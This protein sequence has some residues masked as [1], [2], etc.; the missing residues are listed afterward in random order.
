MGHTGW[1]ALMARPTFACFHNIYAHGCSVTGAR[2]AGKATKE[3][4]VR[5]TVPREAACELLLFCV[6]APL[7]EVDLTRDWQNH[8]VACDASSVFGFGVSVASCPQ[9][10]TRMIGRAGKK[11][12]LHVRTMRDGVSPDEE[13]ERPRAGE[14]L[15]IPL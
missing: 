3:Q 1:F 13:P 9:K 5:H 14:E 10:L 2:G 4:A 7:L 12:D 8:L 6:L 15:R 11:R